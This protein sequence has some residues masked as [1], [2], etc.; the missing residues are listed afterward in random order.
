MQPLRSSRLL[1]YEQ[2]SHKNGWHPFQGPAAITTE[3]Y[4]GRPPV[5]IMVFTI[6]VAVMYRAKNSTAFSTI[7]RAIDT[8]N[9]DIVT[10]VSD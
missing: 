7:P 9:L 1:I 10:F 2:C 6:K 8:G 3:V 5:N 4:D